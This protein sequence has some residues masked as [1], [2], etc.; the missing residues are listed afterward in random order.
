MYAENLQWST[1]LFVVDSLEKEYT[2][3]M[4][5]LKTILLL[6]ILSV[7]IS[8]AMA[9]TGIDERFMPDF[10]NSS[11][12]SQSVRQQ[13]EIAV[14]MQKLELLY[15]L[16]DRDFLF[17]IDHKVVYENMAKGLFSG[18]EDEYSAYVFS[19][20]AA[21]FSED[22]SGTY[23]G[24]GAY[25]SKNY[26]EYRDYT[27]PETYM[28]NIT[29]VFPGSPA[30]AAGLRSGDLISHIDAKSV[31]DMEANEAS[32]ALKG[33]P[34][35]PVILTI[36]RGQSTFDVT[37]IRRIVSVPTVSKDMLEN[38][39]G[40]LRITQFTNS[41]GD[42]VKKELVKF[43]E[44]AVSAIILDLR[45]NPGGIVDSTLN[46]ADMFLADSTIVHV[47][48]KKEASNRTFVASP[49]TIIPS[50]VPVVVLVNKGSASSSEIL[51][52]ALR[53]NNRATLI[54]TTTYGK[55][56]IQIVS[57]FGDGYYT[58]TTSQYKT[59]SGKDIHKVGIP[60]DI[61]IEDIQIADE[62]IDIYMEF[63]NSGVT[64]EFV[65]TH[66]DSSLANFQLFMENVV[67]DD[68]PL[69]KDVYRLLLR[70]EY[71]NA[72]PFDD[73]P[74]ADPEFDRVLKR[75]LEFLETGK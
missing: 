44:Q 63:L 74:I 20:D 50:S 28:V 62:D 70:R 64:A 57:P 68:P 30:E 69:E 35:T 16:V 24:I 21:D 31:D 54:G 13:D 19:K 11:P 48:S 65:E 51:S 9:A 73:R 47:N 52:G 39:I 49:S 4:K 40:Y 12:T 61:E 26:L 53:D 6:V 8:Q 15:R 25:I 58:L 37:V 27:K 17:D 45:D 36:K 46:V 2:S 67:G 33:E 29:S 56:L 42:Q 43:R 38:N 18:L 1:T 71:L 23:G 59:P 10:F 72:M 55:G 32:R 7:F 5:R 60:V 34:N 3:D 75:A 22:T 14:N 41:T 66:P